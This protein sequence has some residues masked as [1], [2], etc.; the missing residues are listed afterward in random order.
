MSA[1]LRIAVLASGRGS[2]FQAL[3]SAV[4]DGRIDATFVGVFSDRPQAPVLQHARAAGIPAWSATPKA[5]ASRAEFERALFA[6]V[7]QVQP[8]LIVLAGYMRIVSDAHVVR[9][10]GRMINIHPSLLPKY[11]GLH[12]HA[13]AL[14]AGDRVHGASV[15]FVTPELDGGPAIAQARIPVQPGDDEQ[16]LAARVLEREHPLLVASVAAIADGSIT[17]DEHDQVRWND[18]ALT[19]PLQLGADDTLHPG[20]HG[21]DA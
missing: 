20:G 11:P 21:P 6:A 16:A 3:Q 17:L 12:T 8:Q 2:N 13:R 10:R 15:H 4:A 7:E 1:P 14:A 5:F 19:T 9:W 18:H